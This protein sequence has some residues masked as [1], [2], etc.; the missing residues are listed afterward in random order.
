MMATGHFTASSIK[1]LDSNVHMFTEKYTVKGYDGRPEQ[2]IENVYHLSD[3]HD[4]NSA[5]SLDAMVSLSVLPSIALRYT[6]I[7]EENKGEGRLIILSVPRN[8]LPRRS[9]CKTW[10]PKVGELMDLNQCY[11]D[12]A[13]DEFQDESEIDANFALPQEYI[14]DVL[15][16]GP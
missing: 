15:L 14:K 12:N 11:T 10:S 9:S 5:M 3:L 4:P 7:Q 2:H 6:P 1:V 16:V 13:T 8:K